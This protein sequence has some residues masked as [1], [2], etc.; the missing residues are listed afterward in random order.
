[1]DQCHGEGPVTQ[2]PTLRR[3]TAAVTAAFAVTLAGCDTTSETKD[4]VA[5]ESA[6]ASSTPAG[7]APAG[8]PGA[9][10]PLVDTSLLPTLFR[11]GAPQLKEN[12][13][14]RGAGNVT[15]YA[16]D[17]SD[18]GESFLTVGVLVV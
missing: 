13:P 1:M 14:L 5:Q 11:G 15:A 9:A 16:C 6:G 3:A 4:P 7:A 12:D 10:C 2:I 8:P 17:V 18:E